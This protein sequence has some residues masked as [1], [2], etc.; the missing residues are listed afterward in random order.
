MELLEVEFAGASHTWARG[1]SPETRRSA[2]LDRALCN[3]DWGLRFSEAKVKHLP[4]I[5]Y[6]HC[7]ILISLNGF[8]PLHTMARPFYFQA[9]WMTHEN[10][11]DFV[12]DHWNPSVPLIE[13]LSS[14]SE[15]LQTWS[16]E[17]FH[18][19]FKT[20]KFSLLG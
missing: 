4:S 20:K 15:S 9:T 17:I 7:P 10:F 19:I 18:N 14:L 2:R 5:A 1:L 8:A 6:D 11:H 12:H 16:K 13:S 3:G